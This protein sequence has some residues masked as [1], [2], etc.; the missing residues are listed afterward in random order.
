M[1]SYI[2]AAA[3]ALTLVTSTYLPSA[4]AEPAEIESSENIVET[5]NVEQGSVAFGGFR[6]GGLM[7]FGGFRTGGLMKFGGFRTGGLMKFGGF[8]TGGLM[9]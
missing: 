5:V 3:I 7:K 1:N 6:T 4:M 2:K 8:R 9:K